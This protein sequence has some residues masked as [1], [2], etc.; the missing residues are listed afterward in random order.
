M[1]RERPQELEFVASD[2]PEVLGQMA[3]LAARGNGW[4]NIEPVI[5]EEYEP[6]PPGPFAFLGGS[7]HQVTTATWM[8]GRFQ[9]GD[10]PER[11][12]SASSTPPAPT[13]PVGCASSASPCPTG[14]ASPRTIRGGAWW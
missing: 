9:P 10:R 11:P 4:I 3:A 2:D 6:A 12:P 5:E 14:G 13:W 8:P 1:T 7:T